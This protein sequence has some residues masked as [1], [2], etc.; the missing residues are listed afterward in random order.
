MITMTVKEMALAAVAV[1]DIMKKTTKGKNAFLIARLA[2]VLEHEY[3]IFL[4][5]YNE[6]TE[7]YDTESKEFIDKVDEM[8]SENI[9]LYV[10]KLPEE[11][12]DDLE[13]EISSAFALS[14]FV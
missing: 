7:K 11:V 3:N 1:K 14:P 13:L 9:T 4:K 5:S 6:L 10:D 12:F 2:K 8:C